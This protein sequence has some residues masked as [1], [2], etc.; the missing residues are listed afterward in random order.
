MTR[1][2]FPADRR[3]A[4][5]PTE[6]DYRRAGQKRAEAWNH[7]HHLSARGLRLGAS[8]RYFFGVFAAA[9][10]ILVLIQ[11]FVGRLYV[12]PSASMEP[13]LHGCTGCSN[14]RI[15][16]EK[17]SYRFSQ[18]AP[19]DI[20]VFAGP[21]SWNTDFSVSRSKNI[22]LRGVQN[23]LAAGGIIPNGEN[24]LVKR[25]IATGGQTVSCQQGDSAIMVD[26]Q[27]LSEDYILSP[28][29]IPVP[30]DGGSVACGGAYFG[31]V[32]VPADQLWV[33]GDNRTNSRDSRAHL[34][35]NL[36]G[37][38]PLDNVRGKVLAVVA[39]PGRMGFV[40]HGI[41]R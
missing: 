23:T 8:I 36:Q 33:M 32:T 27:P 11:T 16:V 26:G 6:H 38:I 15:V 25:I 39:P 30:H 24:I 12:I 21:P 20:V 5:E 19:G 18:P 13:T 28:P 22:F 9:V 34:G 7:P 35:D 40:E 10:A 1:N 2:S 14:D 41:D 4:G 17:L 29:A 37:T 31:P 3:R